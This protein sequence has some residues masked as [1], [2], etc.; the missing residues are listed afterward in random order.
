[1]KEYIKERAIELAR[2]IVDA[3]AT[4]RDCA[5]KHN[6]S[7]STVHKDVTIRLFEIDYDLFL[8]VKKVLEYNFG[9]RHI[10]GGMSTRFKYKG[11]KI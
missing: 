9:E 2:C 8:Q 5:K 4:V 7:K 3:N 10:R 1:M 11:N 6:V